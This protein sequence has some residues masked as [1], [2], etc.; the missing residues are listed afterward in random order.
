ML[1]NLINKSVLG[2]RKKLPGYCAN[3]HPSQYSYSK[4]YRRSELEKEE[5]TQLQASI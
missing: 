1:S 4:R 2:E 3:L 5:S